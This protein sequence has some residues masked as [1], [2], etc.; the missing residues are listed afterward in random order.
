MQTSGSRAFDRFRE[1]LEADPSLRSEVE[2]SLDLNVRRVNPSDRA[3][4]FGSG[5]AVEWILAAAAFSAGVLTVPGGHNTNGFDLRDLMDEA[6]DDLW[7]V[8][9]QT[10]RGAFRISNGLGGGGRGLVDT[11]VFLSPALPGITLVDPTHHPETAAE[12]VQHPD[13]VILPFAAVK[14]HA[15]RHPEC[16]A[17]CKMPTNP[18]TGSDDPW[19]DYV[20]S[21]LSPERFPR[22]SMMFVQSKPASRSFSDEVVRLA[23]LRDEGAISTDQFADLISKL[24]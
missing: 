5:A 20:A 3:N 11:T 1:A 7:S 23:A 2:A 12:A 22:L 24:Q 19:L 18:G 14:D 9:N 8:K 15:E 10:K 16:V 13:A 17:P 21:L 6:R 4:R